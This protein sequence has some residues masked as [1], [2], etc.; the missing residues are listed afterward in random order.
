MDNGYQWMQTQNPLDVLK[1][2]S[3]TSVKKTAF[4]V[5]I[6]LQIPKIDCHQ[7][8]LHSRVL[9]RRKVNK[10]WFC[11]GRKTNCAKGIYFNSL[12]WN[13][14]HLNSFCCVTQ[15]KRV[16]LVWHTSATSRKISDDCGLSRLCPT[17]DNYRSAGH[18][19]R[20][21]VLS[22]IPSASETE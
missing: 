9:H 7:N 13:E 8:I 6:F 16:E 14:S 3:S 19:Y 15:S 21:V 12:T 17:C 11:T 4:V 10:F 18:N 1:T 20:H 5:L 22:T 2:L